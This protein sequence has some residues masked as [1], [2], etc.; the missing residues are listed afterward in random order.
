V[1]VSP[2]D[3]LVAIAQAI[4]FFSTVGIIAFGLIQWN[5]ETVS[6]AKVE[7]KK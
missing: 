1:K 5:R 6:T 4:I 3:T 2:S 7:E